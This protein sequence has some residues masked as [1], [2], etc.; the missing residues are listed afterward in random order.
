[1]RDIWECDAQQEGRFAY[2]NL[3]QGIKS[4]VIS[5]R[6]IFYWNRDDFSL[7]SPII[8]EQA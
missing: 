6:G 5:K 3:E 2:R 7:S 4:P 8:F 1:M